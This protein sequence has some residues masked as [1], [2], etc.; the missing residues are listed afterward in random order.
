M[1][2]DQGVLVLAARADRYVQELIFGNFPQ[3]LPP[4]D[5]DILEI[6]AASAGSCS[7]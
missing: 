3:A 4:A 5:A 1:G 7:R 2:S 6:A